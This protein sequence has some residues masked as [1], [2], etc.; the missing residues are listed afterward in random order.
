MLDLL[1]HSRLLTMRGLVT[2]VYYNKL[3]ENE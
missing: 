3:D 1:G 2:E